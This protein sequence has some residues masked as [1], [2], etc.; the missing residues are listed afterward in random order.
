[1]FA[2]RQVPCVITGF[3][4]NELIYTYQVRGPPPNS[5]K[6]WLGLE[7]C[8]KQ[9]VVKFVS[10]LNDRMQLVREAVRNTANKE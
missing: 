5:Q 10:D 6:N 3:S 2:Y 1:V 7:T 9:S 8:K 4:P